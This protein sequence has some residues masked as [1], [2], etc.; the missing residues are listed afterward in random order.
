MHRTSVLGLLWPL[1]RLAA[2]VGV[3]VFAFSTVLDLGIHDFPAFLLCGLI[4]WTWFASGVAAAT[5]SIVDRRDLV[6]QPRFPLPVIPLVA[7]IVPLA[8]LLVALPLVLVV[9]AAYGDLHW[10]AVFIP[11]LVVVQLLLMSGIAWLASTAHVYLRDVHSAIGVVLALLFYLTPV[12]Y[13]RASAPGSVQDLLQ[14]NPLTVLVEGWRDVLLGGRLPAAGPLAAVA[15][16]AAVIALA[17]LAVFTR[18]QN[19]FVDEL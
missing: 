16:A 13:R 11:V 8:D 7:L 10:T 9:V 17:G 12:F 6:F 1:I 19:G 18:H 14:L 5:A 4:A 2:Q 15:A 3:L